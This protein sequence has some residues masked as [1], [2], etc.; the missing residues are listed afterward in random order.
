[1]GLLCRATDSEI[2]PRR[3]GAP[4][5]RPYRGA[6]VKSPNEG[7]ATSAFASRI[8]S[9]STLIALAAITGSGFVIAAILRNDRRGALGI[10]AD[11]AWNTVLISGLAV[12]V[13]GTATLVTAHNASRR[14][15][16][17]RFQPPTQP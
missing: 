6:L 13:V 15:A 8:A 17:D 3:D 4:S 2:T 16:R 14:G 5:L 1:M 10:V 12:I 9:R 11:V 7:S